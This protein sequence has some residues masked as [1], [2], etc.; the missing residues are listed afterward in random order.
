MKK[1]HV[2]LPNPIAALMFGLYDLLAALL[3]WPLCLLLRRNP[4]FKDTL[5]LRLSLKR[6]SRPQG[7][8]FW[9]HCSSLGEVRAVAPLIAAMKGRRPE[10]TIALSVMTAAGRQEA[11]KITSADMILPF[12]FDLPWVMR[13]YL[14]KLAPRALVIVE[15]EIWPNLLREAKKA[16]V[17]ALF[18][19]ARLSDKA[20][21]RYQWIKPFTRLLLRHSEILAIATE[22]ASR[23]KTLGAQRVGIVGNLKFDAVRAPDSGR[24]PAIKTSLRCGDRPVFIAGSVRKGE[25]ALV[26]DAVRLAKARVPCIFPI[27]APRHAESLPVLIDLAGHAGLSWSLRSRPRGEDLIIIDTV[28]ELFDLYGAAQAAFVGG[29]LVDL[30][31][32]NILEP[33]AWGIPTIHGPHMHNF[34]WALDAIEGNTIV[35]KDPA[36]LGQTVADILV[37]PERYALMAQKAREN[38]IRARGSTQRYLAAILERTQ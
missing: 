20:F 27:I 19:N 38:L 5:L 2:P 15:T 37:H 23:F 6:T 35:V 22:D 30:G 13:R 36:E 16:G 4:N 11:D 10:I 3:V 12:P 14:R 33:I 18:I 34:K 21:R 8:L 29:S 28:G 26:I 7:E 17:R 25:E 9:F 1:P 31:G 32:Q 24:V